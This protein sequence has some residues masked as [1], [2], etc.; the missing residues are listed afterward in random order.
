M[1]DAEFLQALECCALPPAEFGHAGHVRACYLYLCAQPFVAALESVCTAI[2]R[3]A[4]S[5]GLPGRYHETKTVAYVALIHE[6][7]DTRGDAGGWNGFAAANPELFRA[8]LLTTIY[9]RAQ[10]D[11][12][13]A[14]AHLRSAPLRL[15]N[16][17]C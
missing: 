16:A 15:N 6:H 7:L 1:T 3:Y 13:Q 9:P 4:G 14:A 10:L 2:R 11:T 12:D 5:L 8:D 17:S